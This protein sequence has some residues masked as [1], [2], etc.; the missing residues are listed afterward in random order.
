MPETNLFGE[1]MERVPCAKSS[2][3]AEVMAP[4]LIRAQ[5]HQVMLLPTNQAAA[6][7]RAAQDRLDR[8]LVRT[9][10]KVTCVLFWSAIAYNALKLI[11]LV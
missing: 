6:P 5:R 7:K 1:P 9:L 11:A 10:P 3:V 4:K 2:R 8:F